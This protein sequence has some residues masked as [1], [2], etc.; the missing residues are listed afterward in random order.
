MPLGA[1]KA[2]PPRARRCSAALTAPH[3][4]FRPTVHHSDLLP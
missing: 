3:P 2:K 1:V 4:G